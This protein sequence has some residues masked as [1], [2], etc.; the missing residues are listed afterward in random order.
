[1]VGF[2]EGG[3]DLGGGATTLTEAIPETE[4]CVVAPLATPVTR[5]F[6]VTEPPDDALLGTASWACSSVV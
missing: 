2:F 6:S 1:V 4:P 5:T 3:G